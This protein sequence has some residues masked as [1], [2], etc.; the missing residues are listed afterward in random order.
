MIELMEL[1]GCVS[2]GDTLKEAKADLSE[3]LT[4][5]I[6]YHGEQQL[7]EI[8]DGAHII[9]LDAPMEIREFQYINSEL[10]NM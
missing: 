4:L 1:D 7:P 8:R 6:Q 10:E 5:W 9:Y 2:F 3:A